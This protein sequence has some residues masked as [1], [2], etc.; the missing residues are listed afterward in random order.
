M[1]KKNMNPIMKNHWKFIPDYT[2]TSQKSSKK[3]K[4]DFLLLSYLSG[5]CKKF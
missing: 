2:T 3:K 1:Q 5:S 4:S